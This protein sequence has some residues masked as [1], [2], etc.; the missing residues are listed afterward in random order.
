LARPQVTAGQ[1]PTFNLKLRLRIG[2]LGKP[3]VGVRG[4]GRSREQPA[5]LACG[6][7]GGNV[8]RRL[9]HLVRATTP[10][11]AAVL[12]LALLLGYLLIDRLGIDA[13]AVAAVGSAVAAYAALAAASESRHT[14]R[15]A[16]LALATAMKPDPQM[17]LEPGGTTS[18]DAPEQDFTLTVENYSMNAAS[19]L[20]VRWLLR[21]G[22]T[23]ERRFGR[24]E[25]RTKP[26]GGMLHDRGPHFEISLGQHDAGLAGSDTVSVT[27]SDAQGLR[28]W[29]RDKQ[30]SYVN[31]GSGV[32]P[33]VIA[34]ADRLL[35]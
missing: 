12:V 6:F 1:G 19:H 33:H 30:W 24:L 8:R 17:L 2:P 7:V 22:T 16:T 29:C 10:G 28:R 11:R 13:N 31:S 21:D 26:F 32:A 20:E 23:D 15:E 27:F 25:G 34:T 3:L 18:S 5:P 4:V 9:R 14:A 35:D